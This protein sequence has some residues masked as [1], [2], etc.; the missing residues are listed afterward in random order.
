[1]APFWPHGLCAMRPHGGRLWPADF[2]SLRTRSQRSRGWSARPPTSAN[3]PTLC[4]RNPGH[5]ALV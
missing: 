1:L 2:K 5:P 4:Q 3:V